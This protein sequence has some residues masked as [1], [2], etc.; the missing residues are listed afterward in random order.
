MD[1]AAVYAG[2]HSPEDLFPEHSRSRTF[3]GAQ[4]AVTQQAAERYAMAAH[5][6]DCEIDQCIKL[7]ICRMLCPR[8]VVAKVTN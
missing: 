1:L 2:L 4:V 3:G 6:L 5:L 7:G 8:P